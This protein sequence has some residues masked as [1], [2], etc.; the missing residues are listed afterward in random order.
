VSPDGSFL[1]YLAQKGATTE[2]WYRSLT[3]G[4]GRP[5][6]GTEGAASTPWVSPDGTQ[7]AYMD[8]DLRMKIAGIDGGT[9]TPV[10]SVA[11]TGS[12]RETTRRRAQPARAYHPPMSSLLRRNCDHNCDRGFCVALR[13]D[14]LGFARESTILQPS[15]ERS[16]GCQRL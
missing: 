12:Q 11:L 2:L 3:S 10:A 8:V 13:T 16:T 5:V 14:D 9:V 4:E 15:R 1:V 7:V 6:P